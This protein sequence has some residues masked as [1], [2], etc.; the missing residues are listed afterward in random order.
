MERS[1][2]DNIGITI[3]LCVKN[4][5]RTIEECLKS[6][7]NQ[8]YPK[9]LITIVIVDG[10]SKDK[11]VETIRSVLLNSG[12]HHIFFSD[13]GAG[14]GVARQIVFKNTPDKY[15]V[16]VDGDAVIHED[17]IRNQ[18]EF[19]EHH[20]EV[21]VATGAYIH[22]SD[23]HAN[24]SASIE[25]I[26]KHVGSAIGLS[27]KAKRGLPPNDVSIYRVDALKQVKGFDINIRGA[28]EDE[29]VI[30]RM[31]RIGWIVAV[32]EQ[33]RYH[34]FLRATWQDM[35]AERVWFGYGQHFLGHK[36]KSM[37][38][39]MYHNP[40]INFYSGFKSGIQGYKLTSEKKSFLFPPYNVLVTAAWW[41]GYIKAH[42]EGYGHQKA[43]S[44]LDRNS[45]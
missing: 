29:D 4:A 38:V 5:A 35:W 6:I 17:F 40:L 44:D 10:K 41:Q 24:L 22:K 27:A 15:I 31:R 1:T 18:V 23:V 12:M 30:S 14:L 36:D 45:N 7:I 21:C 26:G 2:K 9:K 28:S 19:M 43:I 8:S 20:P 32:N 33:A 11:T 3:G 39:C 37:H 42:M 16:W 34:V 13:K 25:S